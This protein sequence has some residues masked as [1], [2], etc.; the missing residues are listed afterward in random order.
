MMDS[1]QPLDERTLELLFRDNFTGL[2][3]FAYG[4]VKDEEA[5]KEIVQDAF[6]N[7]WERRQMIDLSKSVKSYLSTTVRNKCLN[8]L[9]DHKKFS[10][11]L[12]ELENLSG[13]AKYDHADKL[14]EADIRDQIARAIDELPEKCREIFILS[15][16]HHLKY[17]QIADHLGISIKT[18]ETQMSKALQHLRHRL[19]EYLPT[20]IFLIS[21]PGY[22]TTSLLIFTI[23]PFHHFAI[24]LSG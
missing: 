11:D 2:C 16:N 9:R 1:S 3:R 10:S 13:D 24:Y 21:L 5:A 8:Y 7:L 18:V 20:F 15:R 14:V 23:S 6:V 19:A 17:Q 22:L 12:I 4:Y